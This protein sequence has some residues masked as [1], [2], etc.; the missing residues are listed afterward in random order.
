VSILDHNQDRCFPIH[1]QHKIDVATGDNQLL[2]NESMSTWATIKIGDVPS[3]VL[4]RL[5]L[6]PVVIRFSTMGGCPLEV[7]VKRDVH[8]S[9]SV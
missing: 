9:L 3:V 8:P 2:Y 4:A 1:C 7:V 6:E 5:T